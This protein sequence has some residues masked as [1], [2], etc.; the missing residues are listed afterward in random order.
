MSENIEMFKYRNAVTVPPLGMIDDL[1]VTAKCGPQSVILNAVINAKI[2]LK[3]LEFNKNKCVKL[4]I[5]KDQ[6]NCSKSQSSIKNMKC[7]FLE[8]QKS[9]MKSAENEKY[10]GDVISQNG[11]NDANVS[12]RR[13]QGI[14]A[15][16]QIF[17]LLNEISLGYHYIEI[18]LIL[19]EAIL[20]SKMLL[21]AESWHRL[22]Q[23]QIEKL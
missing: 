10:I 2:N 15:I 18:G 16:S 12:R 22:F 8:V 4:H 20:L 3:K 13:S 7:V 11:S 23:Y 19:R 9:E 1:A 6:F 17:A 14:G 5:C 21:S